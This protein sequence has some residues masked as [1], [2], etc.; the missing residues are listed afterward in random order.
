M[1]MNFIE[2]NVADANVQTQEGVSTFKITITPKKGGKRREYVLGSAT[3][4]QDWLFIL[5]QLLRSAS[6]KAQIDKSKL[7][8]VLTNRLTTRPSLQDL[9]AK[10]IV[11]ASG[12]TFLFVFVVVVYFRTT[13]LF[14]NQAEA[15]PI[16]PK[17]PLQ[18][19][20]NLK[21]DLTQSK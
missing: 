10:N 17:S 19:L 8:G 18:S 16:K 20:F 7:S 3:E 9:R 14:E 11:A 4:K 13:Q 12:R 21:K 15:E 5:T 6:F 2:L 1:D